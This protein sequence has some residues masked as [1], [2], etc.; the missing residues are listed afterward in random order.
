MKKE[1]DVIIGNPPFIRGL[2]LKFLEKALSTIY[3]VDL[4]EDNVLECKHRLF[5][6]VKNVMKYDEIWNILND[7]IVCADSLEYFSEKNSLF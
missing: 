4:M 1:F 6:I 3:G 7:N 5:N 2:H